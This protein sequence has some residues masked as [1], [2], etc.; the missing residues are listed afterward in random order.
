MTEFE[1]T[2]QEGKGKSVELGGEA[3][4]VIAKYKRNEEGNL[5]IQG[6]VK[7]SNVALFK[8]LYTIL[9]ERNMVQ[10]L[11]G[12]DED[13]WNQLSHGEF[14]EIDGEFA[15]S[16][17]ELIL[18]SVLDMFEEYKGYFELGSS[19][20]EIEKNEMVASF[21]KLNK[22]TVIINP[23]IDEKELKFFSSLETKHFIEDRYDLEGDFSLFGKV[24]KIYKPH[25]KIDLIKLLPG[26]M[27]MNKNQLLS[28]LPQLNSNDDIS[29]D[30]GE[31]NEDSFELNGPCIEIAP[32]AIYQ[33]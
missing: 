31:I 18:S 1:I 16:P 20:K 4:K 15:Q 25:Q 9:N 12:F 23:F 30:V 33:R 17:A 6:Q 5:T 29:F 21:I 2:K 22:V 26:R 32:I 10:R 11:I 14:V 3:N 19:E 28:F 24:K 27:K 13:I 7:R 8:D